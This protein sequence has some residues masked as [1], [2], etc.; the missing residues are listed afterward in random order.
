M[1]LL[2]LIFLL[3]NSGESSRRQLLIWQAL[4][5]ETSYSVLK[6]RLWELM[7]CEITDRFADLCSQI[8]DLLG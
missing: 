5:L 8:V 7:R 4:F 2:P 1:V 6:S 3:S